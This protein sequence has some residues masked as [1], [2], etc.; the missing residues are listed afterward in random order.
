VRA[1]CSGSFFGFVAGDGGDEARAERSERLRSIPNRSSVYS[2]ASS[3]DVT[4]RAAC[5]VC[6]RDDDVTAC[7]AESTIRPLSAAST[8]V[9]RPVMHA[10]L[11]VR[12]RQAS[13]LS[14]TSKTV[15]VGGNTGVCSRVIPCGVRSGEVVAR[16]LGQSVS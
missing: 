9:V 10:V 7:L 3:A 1:V 6:D 11:G 15:D 5:H 16:S 4:R 14:A 13:T 12:D 8:A 2:T